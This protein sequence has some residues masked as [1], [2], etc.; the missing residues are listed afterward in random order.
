LW[1]RLPIVLLQ[2]HL[3]APNMVHIDM[4]SA[5][6][7]CS[8]VRQRRCPPPPPGSVPCWSSSQQQCPGCSSPHLSHISDAVAPP[9]PFHAWHTR[10]G[11]N[12]PRVTT[13]GRTAA[14][15]HCQ[16]C[17]G[18]AVQRPRGFCVVIEQQHII[19]RQ[20]ALTLQWPSGQC[21]SSFPVCNGATMCE[22]L[23]TFTRSLHRVRVMHC[24]EYQRV[25]LPFT[26]RAP[27]TLVH[28][29][30]CAPLGASLLRWSRVG[31]STAVQQYNL[32]PCTAAINL[33]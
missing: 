8:V 24:T 25:L 33:P 20:L 14:Q 30:G 19:Y 1:R 11:I 9:A 10:C 29:S 22:A 13:L 27:V 2:A 31:S 18:A 32:S 3:E 7:C 12:K 26:H 16:Q 23:V 21:S 15:Q 28:A 5:Q 4:Y 17:S 6:S